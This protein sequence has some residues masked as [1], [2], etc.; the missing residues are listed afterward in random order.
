MRLSRFQKLF[1][2]VFIAGILLIAVNAWLA[3]HAEQ[4]LA[5]SEYWVTHTLEVINGLERSLHQASDAESNAR[6]YLLTGETRYLDAYSA[7]A[8]ALPKQ[9]SRLEIMT[10]DNH[11][12]VAGLREAQGLA[13]QELGLLQHS[14]ARGP[15]GARLQQPALQSTGAGLDVML[16]LN[17]IVGTLENNERRLLASRFGE[18]ARARTEAK[19]TVALASVLD[20]VFILVAYLT[21]GH[22]R[23]MREQAAQVTERLQKLESISDVAVGQMPL[24]EMTSEMLARL[25]IVARADAVALYSYVATEGDAGSSR[26]MVRVTA[27]LGVDLPAGTS[28]PLLPGGPLDRAGSRNQVVRLTGDEVHELP[29]GEFTRDMGTLLI[30]PLTAQKTIIGLLV[31]GQ[32]RQDAFSREDEEL[33][34]RVAD[35]MAISIDRANLLNREREARQAAEQNAAEIQLL[36]DELEQRV[37][38]RTMELEVTNRELEAFS[39]SVSHD[40]RAP[41]RSVDGFSV[42]LAEDYGAAL[43]GDGQHYL[44]RIRAG[45]QR[46]GSL[47]DALLQLSRITRADIVPEP[48]DLSA[49][50]ASVAEDLLTGLEGRELRFEVEPGLR[51]ECDPRLMRVVFENM[52]GNAAKFTSKIEHGL[53]CFGWSPERRAYFIRDNGAGFDQQ[54]AG[55]LFVAFQRLHGDKDFQGSGIG[56]ATVARVIRRHHGDLSAE[57]EVGRG[58]TFWFTLESGTL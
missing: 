29:V 13:D 41:L 33:L 18:S 37:R 21:L 4:V 9:F 28:F 39:Y 26:G 31:A 17:T 10:G 23:R 19:V 11:G 1:S 51:A 46:M 20:L 32:Q 25:K 14:V 27:S 22:E 35:R 15:H 12:Q 58:A 55:K 8:A 57:G 34:E 24:A 43:S 45:V 7:A 3:F 44:N 48:V 50:A 38:Q 30:L 2:A 52:F 5:D 40:L 53:V 54:Y 47:I 42:A 6:G 16:H 36:N 49:L 56:L